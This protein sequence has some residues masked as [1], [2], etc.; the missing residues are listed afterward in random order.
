LSDQLSV[1]AGIATVRPSWISCSHARGVALLRL[2]RLP[3]ARLS[4]LAMLLCQHF[5]RRDVGER[6]LQL[7]LPGT[8]VGAR[9]L[10]SSPFAVIVVDVLLPDVSG[11]NFRVAQP[12][13][14]SLREIL[15][16]AVTHMTLAA[17]DHYALRANDYLQKPVATAFGQRNGLHDQRRRAATSCSA[18]SQS[19]TSRPSS[20]PRASKIP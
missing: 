6:R 12:A 9:D 16:I 10:D 1:P 17:A 11:W 13:D 15:M 19:S 2:L 20:R 7:V 5:R 8:I 18:S 3:A 14:P 4:H